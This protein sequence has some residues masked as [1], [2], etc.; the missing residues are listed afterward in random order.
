[1]SRVKSNRKFYV[2]HSH[3]DIWA[4]CFQGPSISMNLRCI[5]LVAISPALMTRYVIQVLNLQMVVVNRSG[6]FV[7]QFSSYTEIMMTVESQ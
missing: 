7:T 3:Y 4:N 5:R 1:M 2:W 6:H